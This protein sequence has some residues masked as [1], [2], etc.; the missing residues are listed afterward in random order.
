MPS[1]TELHPRVYASVKQVRQSHSFARK[2]RLKLTELKCLCHN[3]NHV[4]L[5]SA[6]VRHSGNRKAP[7]KDEPMDRLVQTTCTEP[8]RAV[9]M[10]VSSLLLCSS[11][12]LK[13]CQLAAP[14]CLLSSNAACCA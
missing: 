7:A 6:L 4:L 14:C 1:P 9:L 11:R 13:P 3:A 5:M 2:C 12:I 8:L 10:L